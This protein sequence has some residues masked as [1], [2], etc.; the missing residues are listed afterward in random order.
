MSD[1]THSQTETHSQIKTDQ[2]PKSPE[3][4]QPEST[5]DFSKTSVEKNSQAW[6]MQHKMFLTWLD[7]MAKNI[8]IFNLNCK[9]FDKIT[10]GII[11]SWTSTIKQNSKE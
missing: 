4:N 9:T 2:V 7:V 11:D 1:K 8:E 6:S 5:L 3:L 10:K